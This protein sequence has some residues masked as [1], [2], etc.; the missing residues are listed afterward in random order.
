MGA[1]Q[2]VGAAVVLTIGHVDTLMISLVKHRPG[3]DI[4]PDRVPQTGD[5]IIR[6]SA[7]DAPPLYAMSTVPG[8]DQCG[9]TTRAE[10]ERQA[11][12]FARS[13]GVSLWFAEN[14]RDYTLVVSFRQRS[15]RQRPSRPIDGTPEASRS[16]QVEDRGAGV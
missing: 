9:C 4:V 16:R 14:P 15:R 1:R 6:G 11:R 3:T 5:V 12:R 2:R 13:C 8:P 10:T 7:P